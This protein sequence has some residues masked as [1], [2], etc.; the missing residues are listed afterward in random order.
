[1]TAFVFGFLSLSYIPDG[2]EVP[3]R[4]GLHDQRATDARSKF[5]GP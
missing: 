3:I 4:V 1:V 2:S 5:F